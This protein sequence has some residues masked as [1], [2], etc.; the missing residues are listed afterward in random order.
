MQTA[1]LRPESLR[2]LLVYA[3]AVV[4]ACATDREIPARPCPDAALLAAN[5]VFVTLRRAGELAGC[6][7]FVRS[8]DSLWEAVAK[9]A[10][11][12]ATEDP[13]FERIGAEE[14]DVIE[15]EVS[16]LTEPVTIG[17]EE[18][19]PGRHGLLL[20]AHGGQGLLLPQVAIEHDLDRA[21]FLAALCRKACVPPAAWRHPGAELLGFEVQCVRADL[22]DCERG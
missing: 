20:R 10:R 11:A 6:I 9:A 18:F 22:R 21:G 2:A 1:S 5:G 15:V 19:E 4:R 8:H 12:A 16:V 7:G 13:R 17:A 14:L 3:G